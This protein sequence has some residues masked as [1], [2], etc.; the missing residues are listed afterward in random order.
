MSLGI[1]ADFIGMPLDSLPDIG[2]CEK[3][4]NVIEGDEGETWKSIDYFNGDRIVFSVES[5][6]EQTDIAY[7][8]TIFSTIRIYEDIYVGQSL[9][10]IRDK[11]D[12][13][14]LSSPD[15]YLFIRLRDD[16]RIS[17]QLDVSDIDDNNPLYY[18]VSNLNDIPDDLK[19]E[20][21]V[22]Y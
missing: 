22:I 7:R 20:S 1:L 19:V 21:I 17:L 9:G 10:Q 12:E 13:K 14:I 18:G 6:W 8:I 5:N 2:G 11:I 16:H 3:K 4:G 15:G